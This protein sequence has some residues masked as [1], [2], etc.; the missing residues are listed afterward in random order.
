MIR[1][2]N[3]LIIDICSLLL[4]IFTALVISYHALILSKNSLLYYVFI[5]SFA[6]LNLVFIYK[7]CDKLNM[8]LSVLCIIG[9]TSCLY[10]FLYITI[11]ISKFINNMK[12]EDDTK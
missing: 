10:V 7:Y 8:T 9:I 2:F 6:I 4:L 12:R 11:I 5:L 1:G 3:K